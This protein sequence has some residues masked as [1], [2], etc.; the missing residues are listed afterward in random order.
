MIPDL[1]FWGCVKVMHNKSN[2]FKFFISK[3]LIDKSELQI[4]AEMFFVFFCLK[5][6]PKS[7]YGKLE[8]LLFLNL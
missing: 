1:F 3:L 8:K 6:G 5:D 2:N 7:G 4:M